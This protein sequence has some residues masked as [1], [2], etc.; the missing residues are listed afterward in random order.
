M[1]KQILLFTSICLC[2]FNC[3]QELNFSPISSINDT[4]PQRQLSEE[5]LK[6]WH[7]RDIILDTIPG[8]SLNRTYD[9]L[10]TIKDVKE[11]IVVAIIDGEI[12]INHTDLKS[13]IWINKD[14]I[15]NNNIDDDNNGYIDDIHGWNFLGNAKGE[16][17]KFVNFE[18]TRYLKKLKPY[19]EN[20]DTLNLN[21]NDKDLYD[22]YGQINNRYNDRMNY[23]LAEKQNYDLLFT[24]YFN[25]KKKL[26]KYFINKPFNVK[27][28]DSLSKLGLK[29][30]S[31]SDFEILINCLANGVDDNYVIN[32][33]EHATNI[34][35]KVLSL[36]FNDRI[37]Q[38][39]NPEDIK[40]IDYGNN[41]VNGHIEYMSHGTKM[42]GIISGINQNNEIEIMSLPISAYGDEHDKDIALAIRYSV[43]NGAKVINMSFSKEYSINKEWVFD[44]FKYAEKKQ[45]F[46]CWD[47]W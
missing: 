42:A 40:D 21:S 16:K 11:K 10:L 1:K 13:K 47:C 22:L 44:A 41:S 37:T 8:I 9:N 24:L 33:K 20:K 28:L 43:D 3:K 46:D 29:D 18:I 6:F 19:F 17:N 2:L 15:P 23:F 4:I 31:E 5:E 45:C 14:E 36:S 30:V 38:G 12:D 35:E 26:D 27:D 25:A 34:I 32:E 7:F 39:D